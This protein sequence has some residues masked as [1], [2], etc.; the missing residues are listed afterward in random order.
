MSASDGF[1]LL[2]MVSESDIERCAS[3]EAK[4]QREV[5]TRWCINKDAEFQRGW[6]EESYIDWR[7]ERVTVRTLG[8]E[9]GEW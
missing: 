9:G 6:I 5:D 1:G 7:R 4:P 8:L 3:E 2:Q